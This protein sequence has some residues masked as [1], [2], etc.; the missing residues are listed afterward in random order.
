MLRASNITLKEA[1][2]WL[3]LV[4]FSSLYAV[5]SGIP[6]LVVVIFYVL[7]G[8]LRYRAFD[9]EKRK[10]PLVNLALVYLLGTLTIFIVQRHTGL[11]A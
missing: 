11:S 10:Y 8:F 4:A 7:A 9:D 3:G 6:L 1:L 5:A 2:V